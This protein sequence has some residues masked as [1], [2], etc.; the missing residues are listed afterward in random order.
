[1]QEA[2]KDPLSLAFLL[3]TAV[4]IQA[5]IAFIKETRAATQA[6]YKGNLDN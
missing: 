5:T 2:T 6:W 3:D 1:M 4:G